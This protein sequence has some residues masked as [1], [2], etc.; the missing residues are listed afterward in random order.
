MAGFMIWLDKQGMAE[1]MMKQAMAAV[2]VI[3]E[4]MGR[5]SPTKSDLVCKIK[6]TCVKRSNERKQESALPREREGTSLEDVRRMV[7][8]LF[9]EPAESVEP[10]RRRFLVMQLLFSVSSERCVAT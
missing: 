8:A 5:E 1:N 9:R 2:N 10:A 4:C 3:C 6:K 7:R